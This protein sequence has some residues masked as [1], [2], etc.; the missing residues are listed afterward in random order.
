[1]PRSKQAMDPRWI[2]T[3]GELADAAT[4][5]VHEA[6]TVIE[7]QD[8]ASI[9]V[10][11][12]IPAALEPARVTAAEPALTWVVV[13]WER[14]READAVLRRLDVPVIPRFTQGNLDTADLAPRAV[15]TWSPDLHD[16]ATTSTAWSQTTHFTEDSEDTQVEHEIPDSGPL[17]PRLILALSA[18]GFGI[19]LQRGVEMFLGEGGARETLAASP[20]LPLDLWRYLTAGFVHFGVAHLLSNAVFGLLIGVVLFGTHGAGAAMVAWIIATVVGISAEA[21]FSPGVIWI[22][23]ASAGNYGL[24]GLWAKGQLDRSRV[25]LLPKRERLRTLGVLLIL[26]PGALT[27]VTGNGTRIAVMAHAAGFVA[28]FLVGY[29]FERRLLP[30]SFVRLE[31]RVQIGQW[32]ALALCGMAF[33]WAGI[34]RAS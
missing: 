29:I 9:L 13:P 17:T 23:G 31:R 8:V 34:A 27:P 10:A 4:V 24:V 16:S 12:G 30:A 33:L 2:K 25:A 14:Q 5:A 19:A 7:A 20:S 32:V 21:A 15:M 1:M 18:I 3:E 22:A 11:A 28:G 26:V 6:P